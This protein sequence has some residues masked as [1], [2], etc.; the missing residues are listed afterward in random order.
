[1]GQV[2]EDLVSGAPVS[3][4]QEQVLG[5]RVLEEQASEAVYRV[6]RMRAGRG[7]PA[8]LVWFQA[9]QEPCLV[10]G[11]EV[12]REARVAAEVTVQAA[13]RGTGPARA[14]DRAK[15]KFTESWAR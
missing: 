3:V 7:A 6:E 5:A 10:L 13:D 9:L 8:L 11:R 15:M 1:V 4:D 12:G 2:S 14:P